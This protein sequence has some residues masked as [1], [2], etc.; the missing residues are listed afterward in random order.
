MLKIDDGVVCLL[1]FF[2]QTSKF[3]VKRWPPE[4]AMLLCPR[5][6]IY[7]PNWLCFSPPQFAGQGTAVESCRHFLLK[8]PENTTVEPA[9][10]EVPWQQA[11][12]STHQ[13]FA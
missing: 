13:A 11:L 12:A 9:G 7:M 8:R 5:K 10:H 6:L 4:A 2:A 3:P 1:V